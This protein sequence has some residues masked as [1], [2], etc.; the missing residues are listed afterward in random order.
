MFCFGALTELLD[1]PFETARVVGEQNVLFGGVIVEEGPRRDLCC[2][3]D[4]FDGRLL[5][6]IAPEQVEG[7]CLDPATGLKL[8]T[9]SQAGLI[10]HTS[11]LTYFYL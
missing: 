4:F 9:F 6:P 7:R 8:L 5:E 10:T 11:I 3:R 2:S 1:Y